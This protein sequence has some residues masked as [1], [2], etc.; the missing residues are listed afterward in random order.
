MTFKTAW[1]LAELSVYPFSMDL[2]LLYATGW[3]PPDYVF[4]EQKN[5]LLSTLLNN[6]PL[7]PNQR[8]S[9][10]HTDLYPFLASLHI[11]QLA[12]RARLWMTES[13]RHEH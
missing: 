3:F 6:V 1:C 13:H 5:N 7:P 9:L 2:F 11:L 4:L 12:L 8:I 10:Y